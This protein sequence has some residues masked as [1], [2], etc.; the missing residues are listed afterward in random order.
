MFGLVKK[1]LKDFEF[2]NKE[3]LTKGVARAF[4]NLELRNFQAFYRKVLDN[5]L[6]FWLYL[7]RKE[8]IM[9][10]E[11]NINPQN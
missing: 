7:D 9:G 1:R 3:E 10:E 2:R 4:F 5:I 11:E 6:Q 8:Y